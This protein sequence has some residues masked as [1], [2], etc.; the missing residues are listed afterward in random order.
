MSCKCGCGKKTRIAPFNLK[1]LGWVSGEPVDYIRGHNMRVNHHR[2]TLGT[3][4]TKEWKEHISK[5]QTGKKLSKEWRENIRKSKMGKKN[6]MYGKKHP[7][8]VLGGRVPWNKGKKGEYKLEISKENLLKVPKG[9]NHWNWKGG[10][11]KCAECGRQLASY[12]A[13]L[14]NMHSLQKQFKDFKQFTSIEKMVYQEL[15]ERGL[16]F[17]KQKLIN[18]KFI[19]D[20]YI[21]SLNLIIEADGNYWH[22][23]DKTRRKDKAENAYLKKC[24]YKLLRLTEEEIKDGSFKIK[25]G[26]N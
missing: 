19:V 12:S 5:I 1:R 14:C 8:Y 17:E 15:R 24:G 10:K 7:N 9:K 13:T 18:G 25:M 23:L 4:H 21:P 22:S 11:P 2:A 3:R 6:P 16:L 26:V 20:A